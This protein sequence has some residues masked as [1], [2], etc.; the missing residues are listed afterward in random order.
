MDYAE[1]VAGK[2]RRASG[3]GIVAPE[4]NP[5]LF[6][7]QREAVTWALGMG[8]AALFEDCGLGKAIQSLEWARCVPGD[9]LALCPLAVASQWRAEAVKFNVGCDVGISRDGTKAGKITITNYEQAHKFNVSDYNAVVLDES[10]CLKNYVGK[11]KRWLLEAFKDTPFRLC[12]TA[13]PAPNDHLELGN[14]SEFLGVMSSH[15][16][17]ARWFI[18]DSGEAGT[19]RLKGHAVADFWDWVSSWAR[20]I[21]K[22]SDLGTYSDD[23]Y[24][25][26]KLERKLHV[27]GVE[28]V[29]GRQEGELFRIPGT[30]ATKIHKEKRLTAPVRAAKVRAIIDS[31]PDEQ[32]LIWCDTD[33]ES[34]ALKAE[35][36]EAIDVRGS[37]TVALKEE[38]LMAFAT[39]DIQTLITKPKIAGFGLNWQ[40]CAR[41]AFVGPTFSFEQWYQAVRR[42]W[43]FGQKRCVEVHMVMAQTEE[44]V[45]QVLMRKSREH[46]SMQRHMFA[47][48]RRAQRGAA[49][50]DGYNPTHMAP[51]PPFM[52][53]IWTS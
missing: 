40:L 4:L 7:W 37:H 23:G 33:Y 29:T 41:V 46:E 30:S 15:Q 34:D 43:R 45:Y 48:A 47:A 52:E 19:Y 36:P 35:L 2:T 51:V 3:C 9:V 8:R 50:P 10:G 20:C 28:L 49:L 25:L 24:V 13:T 39:G 42:C 14:H 27:V 21:G 53:S 5:A 1:F 26:P 44:S 6:D 32:W 38:R 22:P 11:L 16:M 17:I 31:D 18:N 12:C